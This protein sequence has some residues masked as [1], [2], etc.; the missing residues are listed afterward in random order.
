MHVPT[1]KYRLAKC[2]EEINPAP[3]LSIVV[4][5]SVWPYTPFCRRSM[6]VRH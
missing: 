3:A 1:L 4:L 5:L 2:A 6:L